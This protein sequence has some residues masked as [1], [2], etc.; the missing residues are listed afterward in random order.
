MNLPISENTNG[1]R[2]LDQKITS[3]TWGALLIWIGIA[4]FTG[5]T[6]GV[7][8]IGVGTILLVEQLARRRHAV[9]YE[10]VWVLIGAA[11]VITGIGIAFGVRELL[12]PIVLVLVG[13]FL[14]VSSLMSRAEG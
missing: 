9:N 3:C 11:A 8:L 14:F 10:D 5:A 6:W 7:G 12:V 1:P 13:V 2:T 4:L